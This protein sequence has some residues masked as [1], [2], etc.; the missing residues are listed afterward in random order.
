MLPRFGKAFRLPED[1]DDVCY[2]GRTGESYADMKE[3]EQVAETI[4]TVSQMTEPNLKPQESGNRA[5]T[6][7]AAV[8]NGN[9]A[10]YFETLAQPFELGVKPYTDTALAGMLHREDEKRTGTYVTVSAFQMGIGTASCGP[11]TVKEYT[12]SAKEDHEMKI[13]IRV[14]AVK[15]NEE[16]E[17]NN[18]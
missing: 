15:E 16:G 12:Y 11:A 6:R 17:G 4:C 7:W 10:V 3:Q 9:G 2:L 13:L 8:R 1:F 18:E 14:T 5:D